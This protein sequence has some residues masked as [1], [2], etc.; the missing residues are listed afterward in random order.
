MNKGISSHSEEKGIHT[1]LEGKLPILDIHV[2]LVGIGAGNTGCYANPQWL[3]RFPIRLLRSMLGISKEADLDGALRSRLLNSLADIP[4]FSI[5]LLAMDWAYDNQ[6]HPLPDLTDFYIPNE[7]VISLA[8]QNPSILPGISIHP[9]RKDAIEKLESLI[10][11]GGVLVKWLPTSQNFSP[12]DPRCRPFYEILANRKVP[13]LCHT[14]S[15]GATRTIE[16]SWNDPR[17]LIPAL[18]AGVTVIAAHAGMRSSPHDH[19]YRPIWLQLLHQYPNLYGDT[20]SWFALRARGALRLIRDPKALSRLVYGSD[21]PIPSSPWWFLGAIPFRKIL[22]LSSIQNPF[23]RDIELKRAI[24]LP[25][26]VFI[27][28][29]SLLSHPLSSS[30]KNKSSAPSVFHSG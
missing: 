13:L 17:V 21:W 5:V 20:A 27:R 23:L 24:G 4:D 25:N 8:R 16:P 19:D 29:W 10:E 28:G 7:Y 1:N 2:H 3:H 11:A 30:G 15:E 22:R 9:F 12:A 18:D 14:G 6:G 26:E